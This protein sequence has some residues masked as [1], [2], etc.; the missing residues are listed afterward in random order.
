MTAGEVWLGRRLAVDFELPAIERA[1]QREHD[2]ARQLLAGLITD[3]PVPH[4][5]PYGP[6]RRPISDLLLELT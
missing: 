5:E 4:P 2:Q 6:G 1:R 3:E